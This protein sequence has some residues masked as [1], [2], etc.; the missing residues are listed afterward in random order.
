MI[1][2]IPDIRG[3]MCTVLWDTG[4]QISLVTHQYARE[5]SFKGRPAFIRI[6]GVGAGNKN[7]LRVQY[8]V[9]LRKR[10]GGMAEFTPFGVE[11]IIGD[12]VGMDLGKAKELFPA[13]VCRLESPDG[14][15]HMLIG[16]DHM[17]NAPQ[18]AGERRR[19]R[20]VSI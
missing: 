12:A 14:L 2:W 18:G 6:S 19:S 4:A 13:V 20:A 1:H 9:L 5:A 16:M 11:K 8:R 7:K 15:I 10:D 17:K 3:E